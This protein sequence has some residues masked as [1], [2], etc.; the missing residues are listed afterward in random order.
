MR[1]KCAMYC[2]AVISLLF[3]DLAM[4]NSHHKTL[5]NKEIYHILLNNMTYLYISHIRSITHVKHDKDR[6]I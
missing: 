4:N 5:K 1:F 6:K 2:Y 3:E